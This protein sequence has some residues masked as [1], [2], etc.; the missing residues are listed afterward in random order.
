M[1][2]GFSTQNLL[3]KDFITIS[4]KNF[5]TTSLLAN[6]QLCWILWVEVVWPVSEWSMLFKQIV[7]GVVQSI[8]LI[9]EKASR[10]VAKYAFEYAKANGRRRITA[11]HK[12]NI[13]WVYWKICTIH[14]G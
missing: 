13:M 2:T 8:K 1:L 11:V 14:F 9:T 6:I 10:R 3:S 4:Q 12:A 7:D 5:M